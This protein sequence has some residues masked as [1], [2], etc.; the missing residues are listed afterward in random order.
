MLA[1][2]V[3][4]LTATSAPSATQFETAAGLFQHLQRRYLAAG[5][6]A[7]NASGSRGIVLS[8]AY[9]FTLAAAFSVSG[10]P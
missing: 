4:I 2:G 7:V 8:G 10:D 6:G 1:A 5:R 9:L 3:T